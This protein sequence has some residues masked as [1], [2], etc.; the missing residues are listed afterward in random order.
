MGHLIEIS[1][2]GGQPFQHRGF[3]ITPFAQHLLVKVPGTPIRLVWKRPVSV[4]VSGPDGQETVLQI[5]DQTR[6]A[7]W[8]LLCAVLLT[9]LIARYYSSTTKRRSRNG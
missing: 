7:V 5:I 8:A 9:W 1:T 3:R 6:R 2:Q 4:L